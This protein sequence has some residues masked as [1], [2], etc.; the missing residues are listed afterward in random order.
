VPRLR[1]SL[2]IDAL[3]DALDS[4]EVLR[5]ELLYQLDRYKRLYC[6]VLSGFGRFRKRSRHWR[7]RRCSA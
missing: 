7:A 3:Q 5:V 2:R 6:A 4:S 1:G